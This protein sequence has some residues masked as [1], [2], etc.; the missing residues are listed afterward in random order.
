MDKAIVHCRSGIGVWDWAS[1]DDGAEPDL[2]MACAGDVP[3]LET[4]AAVQILRQQVPDLRIRVVNI[5]DL[6][7]LQ[8][9]EYHPHGLSDREFDALFTTDKPVIFAYHGYPWT[10]HRLT[11]RRTNHDNIHVRGYNEEG[12]TTT[13]F[14]MTVLNGLDRFHIVQSVVDWVPRL[15]SMRVALKQ[16]MDSKLL[17]HRAYIR[18]HGQ[19]MPEILEWKWEQDADAGPKRPN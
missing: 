19:D 2:V 4:L 1:T 18:A 17:E 16:A 3:T 15:K 12:T 14:D 10:I 9:K 5:V 8:P 6:M 13:P 7:A 11:Y